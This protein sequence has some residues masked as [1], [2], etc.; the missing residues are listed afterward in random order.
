MGTAGWMAAKRFLQGA[1]CGLLVLAAL[2][3][4]DSAWLEKKEHLYAVVPNFAALGGGR[5]VPVKSRVECED[6]CSLHKTCVAF[7]YRAG[8]RRCVWT[9]KTVTLNSKWKFFIKKTK[10]N[11]MGQMVPTGKYHALDMVGFL[12]PKSADEKT[13]LFVKKIVSASQCRSFCNYQKVCGGYSW[14]EQDNACVLANDSVRYDPDFSWYSKQENSKP[15]TLEL[16]EDSSS[17]TTA[18]GKKKSKKIDNAKR[19]VAKNIKKMSKAVKSQKKVASRTK[20]VMSKLKKKVSAMAAP[21]KSAKKSSAAALKV[22]HKANKQALKAHGQWKEAT[23]H[24]TKARFEM[25]RNVNKAGEKGFR[26]GKKAGKKIRAKLR[27]KEKAKLSKAEAATKKMRNEVAKKADA[28]TNKLV[29]KMQQ[30]TKK[31]TAK[32]TAAKANKAKAGNSKSKM[33]K[34]QTSKAQKGKSLKKVAKV[35][36][37]VAK[38]AA[39]KKAKAKKKAVKKKAAVKKVAAKL[40]KAAPKQKAALKK[41]LAKAKASAKKAKKVVAKKKVAAKKTSVQAKKEAKKAK[42]GTSEA[43]SPKLKPAAIV[44]KEEAKIS[45]I[46]KAASISTPQAKKALRVALAK[47]KAALS[48]ELRANF[49]ASAMAAQQEADKA[50]AA[51]RLT[52]KLDAEAHLLK[53]KPSLQSQKLKWEEVNANAK[54]AYEAAQ[55][56]LA[57]LK[58]LNS[59][60]DPK[61][62]AYS[63]AHK[64]L[65]SVVQKAER[66]VQKLRQEYHR[67]TVTLSKIWTKISKHADQEASKKQKNYSTLKAKQAQVESANSRDG[68]MQGLYNS[69]LEHYQHK[70]L[71]AKLR[72]G[73]KKH[74]VKLLPGALPVLGGL[75]ESKGED[76]SQEPIANKDMRIDIPAHQH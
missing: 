33:S 63:K 76:Q 37:K 32:T 56:K 4:E 19:K 46:A 74:S 3:A 6:S 67:S 64:F 72:N 22:A 68:K 60:E 17:G 40:A 29:Q 1:L 53:K 2:S 15:V 50:A 7:N 47:E 31:A 5:R 57:E 66:K 14:R 10:M 36:K 51:E 8:D 52:A 58:R 73:V 30:D 25:A 55:E 18:Q 20:T 59:P 71:K 48:K 45:N 23:N 44:K 49:K 70:Q 13:G 28:L 69:A 39:K 62:K 34:A 27:K 54:K 65:S 24:V 41:K 35:K 21:Q 12:D 38:V 75:G 16:G 42:A 61:S 9:A 26:E 11:D 43:R